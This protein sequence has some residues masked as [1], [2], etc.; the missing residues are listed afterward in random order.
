METQNQNLIQDPNAGVAPVENTTGMTPEEM[1]ADLEK[2]MAAVNDKMNTFHGQ[3]VASDSQL[4][5]A[6][7]NAIAGLFAVL[8]KNG[9]DPSDPN[10]ISAFLQQL[11]QDNPEGYAIF[12]DAVNSI[13]SQKEVLDKIGPPDNFA[14]PLNPVEQ[15]GV[16]P[17][18][19]QGIDLNNPVNQVSRVQ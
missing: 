11:Q 2:L 9:V 1:T 18:S 8:K 6:Q 15:Q 14:E 17:V 5:V 7:N 13:L 4:T 12:E 16:E 19:P 10:A 3:K